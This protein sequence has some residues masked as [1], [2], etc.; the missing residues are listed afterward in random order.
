M[1]LV[2]GDITYF[3]LKKSLDAYFLRHKVIANNIANAD[4]PGFKRGEVI[5]EEKLK[6]ALGGNF[7]LNKLEEV[8]PEIVL[9]LNSSWRE[10]FNNVDIEKEMVN[11]SKSSLQYNL[12]IQLIDKKFQR[13][14]MAIQGK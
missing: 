12:C 1:G 14:K 11:L 4:T 10:D 6:K 13:I 9:D 7:P 3:L 8:K 2:R 5:F